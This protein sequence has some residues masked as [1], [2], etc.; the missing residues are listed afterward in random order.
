MYSFIQTP[1][2]NYD[3]RILPM[4]IMFDLK[5][6][7][8]NVSSNQISDTLKKYID[9]KFNEISKK[10]VV[11]SGGINKDELDRFGAQLKQEVKSDI[12][13]NIDTL[14]KK[15]DDAYFQNEDFK[16]RIVSLNSQLLQMYQGKFDELVQK[17]NVL[18][19]QN[20]DLVDDVNNLKKQKPLSLPQSGENPNMDN[21]VTRDEYKQ[22]NDFLRNELNRRMEDSLK[23]RGDVNNILENNLPQMIDSINENEENIEELQEQIED[24]TEDINQLQTELRDVEVKIFDASQVVTQEQYQEHSS[25]LEKLYQR[26]NSLNRDRVTRDEVDSI[27]NNIIKLRTNVNTKVSEIYK[28]VNAMVTKKLES[29]TTI[30]NSLGGDIPA[31]LSSTLTDL[32]QQI[33]SINKNVA[34]NIVTKAQETNTKNEIMS[35]LEIIEGQIKAYDEELTLNNQENEELKKSIERNSELIRSNMNKREQLYQGLLKRINSLE[36]K[37]QLNNTD[38][39]RLNNELERMKDSGNRNI[40]TLVQDIKTLKQNVSRLQKNTGN[41]PIPTDSGNINLDELQS[42]IDGIDQRLNLLSRKLNTIETNTDLTTLRSQV[43]QLVEGETVI[44]TNYNMLIST[45]KILKNT[46]SLPTFVDGVGRLQT[47]ETKYI[48]HAGSICSAFNC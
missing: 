21:Y 18:S 24:L 8:S 12:M 3:G 48:Q 29:I 37:S 15:A 35:R 22:S 32:I 23:M 31:D 43:D 7:N 40:Q 30:I 14:V 20:K 44:K 25:E 1:T 4:P 39:D 9:D 47:L 10:I 2:I 6:K 28:N 26:V 19:A 11:P 36:Q 46:K 38:I 27:K 45:L 42:N 33:N 13:I 34:E 16:Q 41:Q 17:I 5:K